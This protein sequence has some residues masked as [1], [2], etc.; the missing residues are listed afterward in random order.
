MTHLSIS[1]IWLA[2]GVV[3]LLFPI[4]SGDDRGLAT[5]GGARGLFLALYSPV[6]PD[7]AVGPYLVATTPYRAGRM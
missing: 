6:T 1:V 2:S 5:L 4:L 7:G 3:L